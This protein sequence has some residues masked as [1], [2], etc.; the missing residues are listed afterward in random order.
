MFDGQI[1]SARQS[2][3]LATLLP[4]AGQTPPARN[5]TC[6]AT[7]TTL[8]LWAYY[9]V[10]MY[11]NA[12]VGTHR[13]EGHFHLKLHTLVQSIGNGSSKMRVTPLVLIQILSKRMLVG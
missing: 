6:R 5:T 1:L 8:N 12:K 2:V 11:R 13:C 10:H 4:L 7:H 9:S 3:Y